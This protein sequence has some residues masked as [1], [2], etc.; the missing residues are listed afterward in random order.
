MLSYCNLNY[1]IPQFSKCEFV[2]VNGTDDDREPL[3]FGNSMLENVEYITLLGSHLTSGV[4]LAEEISLHMQKRYKSVIKFYNFIRSNKSAPL[5]VKIKVLK[6]C[7]MSSLLYNC[8]TF[9]NCV[10]KDLELTYLK[11]LKCCFNVCANKCPKIY[12]ICRIGFLTNQINYS[13]KAVEILQKVSR[14]HRN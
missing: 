2:V 9:G 1:V 14:E 13:F 7:V 10:P 12:F 6:S 8:E 5:K 3:P 4:S 11:L